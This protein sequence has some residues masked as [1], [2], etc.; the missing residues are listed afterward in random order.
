[1]SDTW[2][3]LRR[4]L[5]LP[6]VVVRVAESRRRFAAR[7]KRARAR[8]PGRTAAMLAWAREHDPMLHDLVVGFGATVLNLR[9]VSEKQ[10]A[11]A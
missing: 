10:E 11:S 3:P 6:A 4:D 5:P 7:L 8:D 9:V 2:A 1:M